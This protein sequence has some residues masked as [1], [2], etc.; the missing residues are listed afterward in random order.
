VDEINFNR[1]CYTCDVTY[2]YRIIGEVFPGE[3]EVTGLAIFEKRVILYGSEGGTKVFS[4]TDDSVACSRAKNLPTAVVEAVDPL[5]LSM[6]LVCSDCDCNC[7]CGSCCNLTI[8]NDITA[9]F[10]DALI[11]DDT[12]RQLYVTLGQ[13]ST[14]RL[15]RE[16]QLL[17]PAYDY[18][19]PDRECAG[20]EDD[21]CSLFATV[22]FPVDD[23]F[24]PATNGESCTVGGNCGCC[25]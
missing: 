2:F 9:C 16:T 10:G 7:N 13:F 25:K 1:G 20:A 18:C 21:P 12:E 4:S 8:P 14:I 23:F 6:K 17:I 5:A 22:P 19:I 24:P 3:L 15:E 11:T